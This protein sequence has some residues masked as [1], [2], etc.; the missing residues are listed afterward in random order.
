MVSI[1]E[2]FNRCSYDTKLSG[3]PKEC[4]WP[5][6]DKLQGH[7]SSKGPGCPALRFSIWRCK[8]YSTDRQTSNKYDIADRHRHLRFLVQS[9]SEKRTDRI[10]ISSKIVPNTMGGEGEETMITLKSQN[11]RRWRASLFFFF[12]IWNIILSLKLWKPRNQV[13][14]YTDVRLSKIHTPMSLEL[15]SSPYE[16]ST[17]SQSVCVWRKYSY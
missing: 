17:V 6:G 2:Q 1:S 15:A 14:I 5:T 12:F 10:I 9:E 16:T 7:Q 8:I 3:I 13:A 11:F 4:V